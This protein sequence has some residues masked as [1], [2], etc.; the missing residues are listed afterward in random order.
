M[1]E[2]Y[3]PNCHKVVDFAEVDLQEEHYEGDF[4]EYHMTCKS[5]IK[6]GIK[7]NIGG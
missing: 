1:Y 7:L 2:Y 3:C 5:K 4:Q 6:P